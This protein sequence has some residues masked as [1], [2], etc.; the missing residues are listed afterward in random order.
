M[1]NDYIDK[2]YLEKRYLSIIKHKNFN[3]RIINFITD[4]YKV[5]IIPPDNYW[6]HIEKTLNNPKDIWENVFNVQLDCFARSLV[7]LVSFNGSAIE[8]QDLRLAFNHFTILQNNQTHTHLPND[9][10]F[11]IRLIVGALLNRNYTSNNSITYDLFNPSISDYILQKHN[12]NCDLLCIIFESLCTIKSIINI[13]DL[14]RSKI[15]SKFVAETIFMNLL[16]KKLNKAVNIN[17]CLV[18]MKISISFLQHTQQVK[19]FISKYFNS[20]DIEKEIIINIEDY[21]LI[22]NFCIKEKAFNIPINNFTDFIMNILDTPLN[23]DEF[24]AIDTVLN[25]FDNLPVSLKEKFKQSVIEYW[26]DRIEDYIYEDGCISDIYDDAD[27]VDAKSNVHDAIGI[28]LD[29]YTLT[30]SPNEIIRI[31]D[32]VDVESIIENNRENLIEDEYE[33]NKPW[34]KF[35]KDNDKTV[36]ELIED[37]FDRTQ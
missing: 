23:D 25:H 11:N 34:K 15:I 17:Y 30:F 18:L 32:C 19:E 37:L 16:K 29:Y 12:N 36:N 21:F 33:F 31:F 24:I 14:S 1:H 27:L 22:A 20:I 13:L 28:A 8:E 26:E 3:P 4:H 5:N 7:I 10:D 35:N 2:I 6:N 9:F